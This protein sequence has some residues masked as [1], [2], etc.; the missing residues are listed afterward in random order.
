MPRPRSL[1][2]VTNGE[3]GV[4]GRA[5][6]ESECRPVDGK[7]V[8]PLVV[9]AEWRDARRRHSTERLCPVRPHS[10]PR[11]CEIPGTQG[12]P[13]EDVTTLAGLQL[14]PDTTWVDID[15]GLPGA[16]IETNYEGP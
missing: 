5:R 14:L 2:E 7:P 1:N 6:P 4:A 9:P 16:G 12:G 11:I 3:E 15:A 8:A 13:V 10:S